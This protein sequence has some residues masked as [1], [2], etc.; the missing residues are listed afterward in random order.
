[1][2]ENQKVFR[3]PIRHVGFYIPLLA[4]A[5]QLI[6]F[7][8]A[9]MTSLFEQNIYIAVTLAY[10]VSF[11]LPSMLYI[12]LCTPHKVSLDANSIKIGKIP[13]ILMTLLLAFV[14]Y[15][16]QNAFCG[17]F[18]KSTDFIIFQ[19]AILK[20]SYS[21]LFFFCFALIP[22]LFEEIFYRG[23]IIGEYSKHGAGA[24]LFASSALFATM[25]FDFRLLPQFFVIGFVLGMLRISSNSIFTSIIVHAI[26]NA[27]ILIIEKQ[28][29]TD[30][31]AAAPIVYAI[32]CIILLIILLFM[33]Y[34]GYICNIRNV[35]YKFKNIH[36]ESSKNIPYD[37]NHVKYI[38][39]SPTFILM[40]ILA[41]LL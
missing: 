14:I 8:F 40:I 29:V 21:F 17:I 23:I 34:I 32:I 33:T 20:E 6:F 39:V 2:K 41:F 16:T 4:L 37:L 9:H 5:S 30:I 28:G 26:M 22:A 13:M 25:R 38:F 3:I 7:I 19:G 11:M 15:F 18:G 35:R 27:G 10:T 31:F 1:M 24:A 12:K 36:I